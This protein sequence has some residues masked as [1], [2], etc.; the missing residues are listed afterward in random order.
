MLFN[1]FYLE[2][3]VS[4][5]AARKQDKNEISIL[6][7]YLFW[8]SISDNKLYLKKKKK[9][10]KDSIIIQNLILLEVVRILR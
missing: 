8:F 5:V 2:Q 4:E 10:I 1:C 9:K 3:L 7:F 6:N